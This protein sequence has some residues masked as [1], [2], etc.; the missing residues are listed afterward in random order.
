MDTGADG[1]VC[2]EFK[3]LKTKRVKLVF[4]VSAG[5]EERE[6]TGHLVNKEKI[7]RKE[8]GEDS[9]RKILEFLETAQEAG[10][11]MKKEEDDRIK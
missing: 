2:W 5:I 4:K 10:Q 1:I 3:A 7:N 11:K 9:A 8:S 6:G